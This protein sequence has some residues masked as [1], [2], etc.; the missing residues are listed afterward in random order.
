MANNDSIV[1]FVDG[2]VGQQGLTVLDPHACN[3]GPGGT[4]DVVHDDVTNQSTGTAPDVD[5]SSE[6]ICEI[7]SIDDGRTARTD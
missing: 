7:S 5:R 2:E 1:R 4:A 3:H 6:V